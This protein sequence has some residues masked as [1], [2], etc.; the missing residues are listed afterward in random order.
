MRSSVMSTVYPYIMKGVVKTQLQKYDQIKDVQRVINLTQKEYKKIIKR[1]PNI[2]GGK[3]IFM[4]SYLMG[5]YLI[6]LYK[7][8]KSS[9]SLT[10]MNDIVSEGLKEFSYMKKIMSR[11]DLL[12]T[13]YKN[14]IQNAGAWCEMNKEKY[15]S[16]WL[17]SLYDV[18]NPDLT[19]IVF[20]RCGLCA[21]CDIE[22]VPEFISCLCATDYISMSFANCT[23]DRPTTLG[24]GDKMCDF[25]ITR[26]K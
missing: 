14:K 9:I 6:A 1:A 5:A 19:H 16:N 8:I 11:Q 26:K 4:S 2:G 7:Q 10:Q 23:L 12:S 20:S 15:P 18:G 21:L 22:N 17:V 3:N 25:Y 13:R 24:N